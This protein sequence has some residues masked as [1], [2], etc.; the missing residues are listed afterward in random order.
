MNAVLR[1]GEA[2]CSRI[3]RVFELQRFQDISAENRIR[4]SEA[5]AVF[6]EDGQFLGLVIACEALLF[7]NRI[8]ADLITRRQP[9]PL[10]DN[11]PLATAIDFFN[12]EKLDYA[13]VYDQSG[14]YFGVIS[15]YSLFN[16]LFE[17]E[18]KLLDERAELIARLEHELTYHKI[19]TAV[20]NTTSE[21]IFVAGADQVI[22]QVNAAFCKITGYTPDEALGKTLHILSSGRQDKTFYTQML[23]A[24]K[25]HGVWQGEI[26]NKRK[27]GEIYPEWLVIN[28]LLDAQGDVEN[29]VGVFSDISTH[30]DM[31]NSL[32]RLAYYDPLTSLANRTLLF[33]RLNHAITRSQ[34]QQTMLA[35]CIIDLDEFK[36]VNDRYGHDTGDMLL[37]EVAKR[38]TAV[39]RGEDTAARLGGDEFVLLLGDIGDINELELILNRVLVTLSE[40][41]LIDNK[42]LALSASIGTALYPKDHEDADTLLRHAD[43][44]MYQAKQ[45]GRN[46][47]QVFD[48]S[49]DAKIKSIH[50]TVNRVKKALLDQEM[51]LY[52]QPKVNMRT[53][54][55]VGMEALLRWQHATQGLIHPLDFLPQVEKTDL[56]ID[57]G[58]WVMDQAMQQIAAW[59]K[60]GKSWVVSV[61]IAALHFH[62]GDF[63]QH[64]K[65]TLARYPGVPPA[66][67]EIEILESVALGDIYQV[68]QLIR[69]C[70]AL[71]VSFSLD[72]FGTGYSSLSYLKQ[73]PAE[74]IKIDQ[75]FVRDIMEDKDDLTMVEAVINMGKVFN[76]QVIAE[77]VETPEHGVLL[78][79]LGCDLAQGY[80]I[81]RPMP[82]AQVLDWASTYVADPD[83]LMWANM[84]WEPDDFPLLLAQHNHRKWVTSLVMWIEHKKEMTLTEAEVTDPHQCRF[85]QW[86]Y[87][88]G[89]EF[90]GQLSEFISIEPLHN[91]VH[92]MGKTIL[93]AGKNGDKETAKALCGELLTVQ[94]A[95]LAQ[96][97]QLQKAVSLNN[98]ALGACRT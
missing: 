53:G 27:N 66:L 42:C 61:N 81:A 12:R 39:I 28:S 92:E 63:S 11:A 71:G 18:R 83:W 76:R 17:Y 19:A 55:I 50:Q 46:R 96:F 2:M 82:A 51:V 32:H 37:V 31:Q 21:G 89:T 68:N 86:Y 60:A 47:H 91:Q 69:D 22:Q 78:M 72:D 59:Q 34:R 98:K 88:H 75:S 8:F 26:W 15:R 20:F 35:V 3:V 13:V 25:N 90:Y 41:Y 80:G 33:D 77:G 23:S 56:I 4:S 85:G 48:V 10:A 44:A 65:D 38:L 73:L 45:C 30:K 93:R 40:P 16:A 62:S 36:P 84:D 57:I 9:K 52:Y 1:I 64:L 29:Y 67:L 94:R 70:Q 95:V 7:P 49:L 74:T 6:N 58:V 14:Q 79:R 5:Y 97:A 87:G 43:Q 54:T 24:M